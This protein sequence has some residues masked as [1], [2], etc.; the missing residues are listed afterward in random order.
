MSSLLAERESLRL[1][2]EADKVL[3]MR[4]AAD[5][6]HEVCGPVVVDRLGSTADSASD[7][8]DSDWTSSSHQDQMS[9]K[10]IAIVA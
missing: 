5:R 3:Q 6:D 7:K 1:G 4:P 9:A 2:L 10:G 8:R